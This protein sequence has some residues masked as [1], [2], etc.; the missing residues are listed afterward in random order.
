V[1]DGLSTPPEWTVEQ[2]TELA[3]ELVSLLGGCADDDT[4]RPAMI[5]EALRQV[6]SPKTEVE[7]WDDE[8]TAGQ[9]RERI[10]DARRRLAEGELIP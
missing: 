6:W 5:F 10:L 8:I 2:A 4:V 3:L 9:V 7:A 1:S